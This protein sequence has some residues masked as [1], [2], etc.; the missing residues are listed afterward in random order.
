MTEEKEPVENPFMRIGFSTLVR[1]TYFFFEDF[2][3]ADFFFAATVYHPQSVI[4]FCRK[5]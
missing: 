2:F 3:L 5:S 4:G 1:L